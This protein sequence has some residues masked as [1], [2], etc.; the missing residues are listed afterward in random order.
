MA[1]LGLYLLGIYGLLTAYV[2]YANR[3]RDSQRI[4]VKESAALLQEMAARHRTAA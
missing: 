3:N 1:R 2:V 4:P